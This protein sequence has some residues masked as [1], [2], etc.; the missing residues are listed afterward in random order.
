[1]EGVSQNSGFCKRK[2]RRWQVM[3]LARDN[4][5]KGLFFGN[6]FGRKWPWSA[7]GKLFSSFFQ[8][9]LVDVQASSWWPALGRPSSPSSL[10]TGVWLCPGGCS[11]RGSTE[12]TR[13]QT[14]GEGWGGVCADR[15]LA[16]KDPRRVKHFQQPVFVASRV[17]VMVRSKG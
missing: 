2:P 12:G 9:L 16:R 14:G 10:R 4:Q 1:M 13:S 3:E 6:P 5:G 15:G 7:S 8:L 11:S 17:V